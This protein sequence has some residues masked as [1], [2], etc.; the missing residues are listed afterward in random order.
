M[1]AVGDLHPSGRAPLSTPADPETVARWQGARMLVDHYLGI[2]GDEHVVVA[3]TPDCREFAGYLLVTLRRRG[4][5]A[6]AVVMGAVHDDG[7]EARLAAA[8]PET[9]GPGDQQVV[10]VAAERS[11]ISH[12]EVIPRLLRRYPPGRARQ[13]RAVNATT[14]L[15]THALNRTPAQIT[16]LNSAVLHRLMGV[17]RLEL[18]TAGGSLLTAELDSDRERVWISNRGVT[19][20]GRTV[21]VPSGEVATLPLRL[22]G[23]FVADGAF[24]VNAAV[25]GDT[26]LGSAPVRLEI[27]DNVLV[28]WSCSDSGVRELLGQLFA[29]PHAREVGELG[30]GTNSGIPRFVRMNSFVNERFPGIHI[31]FGQHNQGE[32]VAP[33]STPL[34]LDLIARGGF[35]RVDG[36]PALLDLAAVEPSPLPH[37]A[38]PRVFGEDAETDCCGL[39]QGG[40]D[41]PRYVIGGAP[42]SPSR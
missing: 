6:R 20:D 22:D 1:A 27:R 37:P 38:G 40:R 17:H 19:A 21:L 26:R 10:L 9:A 31:G 4:V 35:V 39:R 28:D 3:Y 34:H 8:L 16:A 23:V 2:R 25:D 15:L 5:V 30:F 13:V 12:T 24:S 36:R 14:E 29:L 11:T 41:V 32:F 33:R 18:T 7:V 42:R